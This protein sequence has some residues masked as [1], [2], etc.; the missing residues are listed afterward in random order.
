MKKDSRRGRQVPKMSNIV[1]QTELIKEI[2]SAYDSGALDK[3]ALAKRIE[4]LSQKRISEILDTETEAEITGRRFYVCADGDDKNDGLSPESAWRTVEKVDSSVE[5]LRPG[6]GV[7]FKRGEIFRGVFAAAPGVTY[8]AY[9]K[10]EKPRIYVWDKNSADPALWEK[11][12]VPGVWYYK[13]DCELDIGNIVFDDEFCARKIYKSFEH[14]GTT[15]DYHTQRPFTD[16]HDLTD[17]FTFFQ[18]SRPEGDKKLYLRCNKGNPGELFSDIEMSKRLTCIRIGKQNDGVILDNL[19]ISYA[20]IHGAAGHYGDNITVRNCEFKWIGGCIQ[21]QVGELKSFFIHRTWPT[22][23]G[24]AIELGQARN[25]NVYNNYIHQCYDAGI[26]HQWGPGTDP[27]HARDIHYFD[28]VITDCVYAIEIFYGESMHKISN[29]SCYNTLIE[30]NILRLGGG[31][32]HDARPDTGVTALIRYGR[33]LADNRDHI[34]RNN[35]F[36]RSRGY[37]ITALNDGMNAARFEDNLYIHKKGAK[38]TNRL[39]GNF[40][41][42]ENTKNELE[43]TGTEMGMTVVLTEELDNKKG[44]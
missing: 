22:P 44:E 41:A 32:G 37:M 21:F 20:G 3:E 34:V 18:D 27:I 9:G 29:R 42:T 24:N 6:D 31:F 28:N 26:T 2:K 39:G 13:E 4:E 15:L 7:F 16:Y 23:L 35:I 12:D 5:N 33:M 36:D 43:L 40:I 14:D 10:G 30:G 17:D 8:S 25:F 38:F 11:T 1:K 19:R